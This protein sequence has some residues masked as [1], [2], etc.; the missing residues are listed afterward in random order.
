MVF[1]KCNHG[2]ED[3]AFCMGGYCKI[4]SAKI[5]KKDCPFYKTENELEEGRVEAHQK[6]VEMDRRDLIQKFEY[7]SSRNW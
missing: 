6:L 1:I 3:C 4:L 7:N 5:T 2:H